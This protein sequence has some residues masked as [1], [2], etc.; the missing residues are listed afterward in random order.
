MRRPPTSPLPIQLLPQVPRA[1]SILAAGFSLGLHGSLLALAVAGTGNWITPQPGPITTR[2]AT[3][4]AVTYLVVIPPAHPSGRSLGRAAPRIGSSRSATPSESRHPLP[5]LLPRLPPFRPAV[6][7][8]PA[9]ALQVV[10]RTGAIGLVSGDKLGPT[11]GAGTEG[12][13]NEAGRN[14]VTMS[15]GPGQR[16]TSRVAELLTNPGEA[17]PELRRPAHLD[18][19]V[20]LEVAVKFVVDSQGAV[21]RTTLRVVNAPGT[22]AIP[23]GF[24]PHI[25]AVG[26]TA[27]VDRSLPEALPQYGAIVAG[28]LLRHVASLRFRPGARNGRPIR[29]SVLVACSAGWSG[30]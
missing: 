21:D 2:Q 1:L 17:C 22:P 7:T 10:L 15:A 12:K 18:S 20:D 25:Y 29:S 4:G 11:N 24:I 6:L 8:L 14:D 26:G 16:G 28:D 30:H 19:E 3:I 5:R 27:R 9:P 23:P 13:G